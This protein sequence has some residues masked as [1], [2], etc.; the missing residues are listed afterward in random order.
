MIQTK[1]RVDTNSICYDADNNRLPVCYQEKEVPVN[2]GIFVYDTAG[3]GKLRLV[4]RAGVDAGFDDFVYWNYS[5]APPGVGESEGDAEPPRWRSSAF[6]AVS[7]RAGATFRVAFLA[8]NGVIDPDTYLYVDPV[9]GIY[10]GEVLG[11][12]APTLTTLVQTGMDGTVLDP[13]AVW[14]DD[15]TSTPPAHRV[16]R[17]GARCFPRRLARHHREHGC[18]GGRLGGYLPDAYAG[19]TRQIT[20]RG[21]VHPAPARKAAHARKD[22]VVMPAALAPE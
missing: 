10:L 9:D 13:D 7:Q 22:F 21:Q 6:L 20:V 2:Q 17:T 18:R 1:S 4:A 19:P 14:D 5:G 12:T 16:P 11:A 3:K 15:G 8:R